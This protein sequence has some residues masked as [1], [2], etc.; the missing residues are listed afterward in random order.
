[1]STIGLATAVG[2]EMFETVYKFYP[3]ALEMATLD[4]VCPLGIAS[5][6]NDKDLFFRLLELGS[7]PSKSSK[8]H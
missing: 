1:M 7:D 3:S 2:K 5:M 8:N 6:N 4:E